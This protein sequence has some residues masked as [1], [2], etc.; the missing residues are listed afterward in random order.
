[1]TLQHD[2]HQLSTQQTGDTLS[3]PDA[4]A[5]GRGWDEEQD[6]GF[7][8]MNIPGWLDFVAA[9]TAALGRL[10]RLGSCWVESSA[11]R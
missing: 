3:D 9:R 4:T 6:S 7:D 10:S 11:A 1:M 5:R 8:D 2:P